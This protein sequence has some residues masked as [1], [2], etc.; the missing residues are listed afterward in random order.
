MADLLLELLSEEIPARMQ[1]TAAESLKERLAAKLTEAGITFGAL[2]SFVSPRHLAVRA[3]GLPAR[4]ADRE[5]ERKG[6]RTDAPQAAIDGFLRSTGLTLDQLEVREK[7]KETVYF[8]VTRE[9]G[10]PLAE[11][12]A[13]LLPELIRETHWQKSM[14]WSDYDMAWVRPLKN[15]ACLLDG[16]VVNFTFNHL[17]SN[18][19]TL[20]HRFLGSGQEITLTSPAGYEQAL[21]KEHVIVNADRR[22]DMIR[23]QAQKA[24]SALGLKVK[25]DP[26]L[27]E[28]VTGLVEWPV[29]LTGQFDD[30]FMQVPPEVLTTVMR[31]HQKYFALVDD[32]GKLTNRF[33]FVSNLH[34][35]DGGKRIIHGNER[36]LRARLSD[37]EFY[38]NLDRKT[39][40]NEWAK[41]LKAMIFHAR[42][43]DMEEKA[44]RIQSLALF[45]AVFVPNAGLAEVERAGEL[46]KADL[47]TGMV[48][49]FPEL[50]G[51]MGRY[52]ALQQKEKAEVADAIRDHYSPQGMH[53]DAPT[54]PVS[55]AIALADKLDSLMGMFAIGE[56]PTGSKDPFA[57]RRAALGII[58][59]V[60]ENQ[61]RIPLK[62]ALEKAA[63]LYGRGIFKTEEEEA[64]DAKRE[65]R[66]VKPVQRREATIAQL[67][68]FF[69][70]RLKVML[71]DSGIRHDRIQ[72]VFQSGEDDDL[73]R[74]ALRAKV[75][76]QY[77]DTEI[78][79]GMLAA[80]RRAVN[81][82]RIEEK[83]DNTS[84]DH[85][86][87]SNLLK[88]PEEK[89]LAEA[90]DALK[91]QVRQALKKEDYAEAVRLLS[92]LKTPVDAFFDKVT[93]NA[94]EANVREN[95]LRLLS[96]IR[97]LMDMIADFSLI[98]G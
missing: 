63:N 51:L 94:E 74:I 58:R 64:A 55:I 9:A 84:Y 67:L 75:L 77:L 97:G 56:K 91:P 29:V 21:E 62:V 2:E 82:L 6:P 15:I 79:A 69:G 16:E 3:T 48:G 90:L 10:K 18:N 26:S 7:G 44:E 89:T 40:L 32:A 83:K 13:G 20:G 11:A 95:R 30:S 14:R 61:L 60:L 31:S 93:V 68:E 57:L 5:T 49:E 37:A 41:K 96:Q 78:G 47:T 92:T 46:C 43:G 17:T 4:T 70:D 12:L 8:A 98:E 35:D 72:A 88:Q 52:Y 24:A 59:I 87:H 65:G 45:L 23:E 22:R 81:I 53:D 50:Q 42:I 33:L 34:A 85:A 80:Y 54:A 19:R 25:D 39:P 66:K 36:V 71:R 86:P 38:W 28:E 73:L 1:S 76:H 27:L